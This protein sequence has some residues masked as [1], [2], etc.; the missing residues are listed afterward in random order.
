MEKKRNEAEKQ[1]EQES[2]KW[3]RSQRKQ[4][5]KEKEETEREDGLSATTKEAQQGRKEHRDCFFDRKKG[6]SEEKGRKYTKA[7]GNRSILEISLSIWQS[8]NQSVPHDPTHPDSNHGES[9]W[10]IELDKDEMGSAS[11]EGR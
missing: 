8:R 7:R 5:R 2:S 9:S 4:Q 1:Q 11:I 6:R 3:Q 10:F